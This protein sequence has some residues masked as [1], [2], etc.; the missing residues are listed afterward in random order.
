MCELY[1]DNQISESFISITKLLCMGNRLSQ[2]SI[3]KNYVRAECEVYLDN[4]LPS[5][6]VISI[7]NLLSAIDSVNCQYPTTVS[8]LGRPGFEAQNEHLAVGISNNPL[9]C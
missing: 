6:R 3:P 4:Q 9:H 8:N 7:T 2:L 5:A 1:L